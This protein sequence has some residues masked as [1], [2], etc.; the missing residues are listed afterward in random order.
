MASAPTT[1]TTASETS[2]R[3]FTQGLLSGLIPLALLIGS[4]LITLAATAVARALVAGAGFATQQLVLPLVFGVGLLAT[5]VVYISVTAQ[6]IRRLRQWQADG[7]FGRA[8]GNLWALGVTGILIVLPIV[9][10]FVLP[11][12]PA[13]AK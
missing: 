1:P 13:V 12:S 11:Q 6:A 9:L 8:S 10:A 4:L 3:S 2:R 7:D 5:I